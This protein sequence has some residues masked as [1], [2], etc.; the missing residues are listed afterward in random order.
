[1]KTE[2][3]TKKADIAYILSKESLTCKDIFL[4]NL[5]RSDT[6][7]AYG[8]LENIKDGYLISSK[9]RSIPLK[10]KIPNTV[11]VFSN[12]YPEQSQLSVDRWKIFEIC[13]DKL[14]TKAASTDTYRKVN[15]HLSTKNYTVYY[16]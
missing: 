2:V 5:L 6:D 4:F 8:L 15:P 1:M 12:S 16:D 9:Y 10:I 3:N 7:V 14:C 13:G 11:V